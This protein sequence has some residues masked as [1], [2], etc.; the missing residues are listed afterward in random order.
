ML[1]VLGAGASPRGDA[2]ARDRRRTGVVVLAFCRRGVGGGVYG[3]VFGRKVIDMSA[4]CRRT[5]ATIRSDPEP[6]QRPPDSV[7]MPRPTVAPMVL[8]SGLALLAAGVVVRPGV[9]GRRASWCLSVGLG[10]WIASSCRAGAISTKRW[11]S[12]RSAP[13]RSSARPGLVEQLRPGMP[14]YRLQI[15]GEGSS[16]LGGHQGGHRRRPGDADPGLDLRRAERPRH[17]VSGQ[18]AGGHGRCRAST[19]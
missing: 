5:V 3:G 14:G 4:E 15:A 16:D 2:A 12:R 1:I 18:P 17:L 10:L 8:S 19:R 9:P 13:D 11:S 7:E 6:E